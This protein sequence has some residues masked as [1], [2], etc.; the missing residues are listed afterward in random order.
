MV[1]AQQVVD[2]AS[3]MQKPVT[4]ELA[5]NIANYAN[6]IIMESIKNPVGWGATE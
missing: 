1:T 5:V 6:A 2:I 4:Y 3:D